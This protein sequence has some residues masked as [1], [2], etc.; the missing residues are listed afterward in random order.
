LDGNEQY[1]VTWQNALDD[2]THKVFV[3]PGQDCGQLCDATGANA[4]S[5][6]PLRDTCS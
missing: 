6:V 3:R 1:R 5:E 4:C 2:Q